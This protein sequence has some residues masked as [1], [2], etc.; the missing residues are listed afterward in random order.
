MLVAHIVSFAVLITS[1][2]ASRAQ[3]EEGVSV[4]LLQAMILAWYLYAKP[5]SVQYFSSLRAI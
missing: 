5:S 4:V 3:I 2:E 1:V